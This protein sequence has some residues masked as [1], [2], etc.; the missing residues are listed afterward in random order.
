MQE[1]FEA[2]DPTNSGVVCRTS[3]SMVPL[4]LQYYKIDKYCKSCHCFTP[5]GKLWR[6]SG[7]PGPV[8]PQAGEEVT[9]RLLVPMRRAGSQRWGSLQGFPSPIPRSL[10]S[11]H[12]PQYPDKYKAQASQIVSYQ[13]LFLQWCSR[14]AVDLVMYLVFLYAVGCSW[15]DHL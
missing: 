15:A 4:I 12:D 5:T 13:I 6:L 11:R 9:G 14:R 1:A 3:V 7:G 10:W 2:K 8:S